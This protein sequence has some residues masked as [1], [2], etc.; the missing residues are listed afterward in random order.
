MRPVPFLSLVL[1]LVGLAASAPAQQSQV[2]IKTGFLTGNT[3]RELS[4]GGK[5]GYAQ[6]FTDGV[7]VAPLFRAPKS[8]LAWLESCMVGMTD[9]QVV[10]ILEKWLNE[11][12]AQWHMQ[13]NVLAYNALSQACPK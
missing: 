1:A 11:N 7:F 3:F 2:N 6:G 5:R 8:E 9:A 13:M 12:P 10:A 4:V